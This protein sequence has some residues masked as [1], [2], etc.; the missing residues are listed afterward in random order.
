MKQRD[1]VSALTIELEN[2][3]TF[4]KGER[5]MTQRSAIPPLTVPHFSGDF[6]ELKRRVKQAGLL[7]KQPHYYRKKMLLLLA[8]F[9]SSVVILLF[10]KSFWLQFLNALY[11]AFITTQ[12]GLLGHDAGHRQIFHSNRKNDIV[13]LVTGN[14]FLGI[15]NEW[16]IHRHNKHH[17]HPNQHDIDPDVYIPIIA[18]APED[19]PHKGKVVRAIMKYQAYFFFPVLTLALFEMQRHSIQ[20]LVQKKVKYYLAERLLLISHYVWYFGLLS[21]QLAIWQ[22]IIFI[23]VH[24]VFSGV[25]MGSVFAPNHKGMPVLDADSKMDFLH[26]QII[27]ARNVCGHPL[28]DFWCGGLNYQIEHHL[29]PSMPRNRLREAQGIIKTF[30]LEHAISYYETPFIQSYRETVQFLHEVSAP[31]REEKTWP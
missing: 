24:Q 22:A 21:S 28:T 11:L 30:C 10:V 4:L 29:F 15:S 16:W 20:Y 18:F 19:L 12:L 17:S 31:L 2:S 25:Y 1:D 3:L 7:E 13:G 14:F 23:L 27:T 5:V 26:R 6:A 9:I 8:L